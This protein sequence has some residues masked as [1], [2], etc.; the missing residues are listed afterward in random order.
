[1]A[2]TDNLG[3]TLGTPILAGLAEIA[4]IIGFLIFTG[5]LFLS[6]FCVHAVLARRQRRTEYLTFP[7]CSCF[8]V[9]DSALAVYE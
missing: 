7:L 2:Q 1:M 9:G 3:T 8:G 6:G 4:G 5:A